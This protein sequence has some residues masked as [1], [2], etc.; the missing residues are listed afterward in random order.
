[1]TANKAPRSAVTNASTTSD[2]GQAS[3]ASAWADHPVTVERGSARYVEDWDS[4]IWAVVHFDHPDH[5]ACDG[6][7]REM[8]QVVCC[9]GSVLFSVSTV[10]PAGEVL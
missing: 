7:W 8:G 1:M 2:R 4:L 9:C 10:Q 6:W 3:K 5:I